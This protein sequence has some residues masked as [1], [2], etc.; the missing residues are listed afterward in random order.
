MGEERRQETGHEVENCLGDWVVV[1]RRRYGNEVNWFKVLGG[2]TVAMS[3]EA[4]TF[5][6]NLRHILK[7][8]IHR[9]C[10]SSI[11]EQFF[12]VDVMKDRMA[13]ARWLYGTTSWK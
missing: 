3:I 13:T 2:M 5:I 9:H 7:N 11:V 12:M 6:D 4:S 8:T 10:W 1:M